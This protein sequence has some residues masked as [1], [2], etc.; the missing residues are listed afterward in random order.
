MKTPTTA[1]LGGLLLLG[2]AAAGPV[3]AIASLVIDRG[4]PVYNIAA[5][6]L[7]SAAGVNR[8][9][10][11]WGDIGAGWM[12]G[13]TFDMPTTS[14]SWVIDTIRVWSAAIPVASPNA[15]GDL[16]SSIT[17]YAD[18]YSNVGNPG[19]PVPADW[20]VHQTGAISGNS[21]VNPNIKFTRVYYQGASSPNNE[22]QGQNGTTWYQ[23]WQ[24]DFTNLNW[25]VN[26]GQKIQFGV[27]GQAKTS[28]V[29]QNHASNHD[30]SNSPQQDWDDVFSFIQL[31]TDVI[32]DC[33]SGDPADAAFCGWDKSSDINVQV[34]ATPAPGSLALALGG[35]FGLFAA[36]SYRGAGASPAQA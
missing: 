12:T 34:F 7:N 9:N 22:Y 35:L 32:G 27:D 10:V 2:A 26:P 24:V 25:L 29:W 33:D 30:L 15:L 36:R 6:N 5:P 18:L 20:A 31:S 11:S 16:Y 19:S 8:S 1:M 13:D 14:A 21:S 4:L 3:H 23:L 28:L 17:L